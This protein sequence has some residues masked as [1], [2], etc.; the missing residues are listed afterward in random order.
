MDVDLLHGKD[1]NSVSIISYCESDFAKDLQFRKST[2]SYIL[3]IYENCVRS[4]WR[5]QIDVSLSTT[6]NEYIA[7]TEG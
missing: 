2:S 6:E 1:R 5:L 4:R 3:T 7:L